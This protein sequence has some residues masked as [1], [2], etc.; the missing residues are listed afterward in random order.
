MRR[1]VD[2]AVF[3]ALLGE[4]DDGSPQI[5]R[6]RVLDGKESTLVRVPTILAQRLFHLGCAY[7]SRTLGSLRPGVRMVI[8]SV[9]V[10]SFARDLGQIRD[11]VNDPALHQAV[12]SLL[13]VLNAG[14]GPAGKS[15]AASIELP[16]ERRA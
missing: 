6:F 16:G 5:S 13:A 11:L 14:R 10:E 9:D 4:E 7:G 3:D 12:E 8:G 2:P 1:S 15:V